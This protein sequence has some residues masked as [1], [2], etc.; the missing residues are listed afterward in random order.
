MRPKGKIVH[1]PDRADVSLCSRSI[2]FWWA[3]CYNQNMIRPSDLKLAKQIAPRV[4]ALANE[5]IKEVN[6][7]QMR[8]LGACMHAMEQAFG[9]DK[10][11]SLAV[12]RYHPFGLPGEANALLVGDEI[13]WPD[14]T[15]G[16][17]DKP[18]FEKGAQDMSR[19]SISEVCWMS[20]FAAPSVFALS[21]KLH[22]FIQQWLIDKQ[23]GLAPSISR[24][25]R[26]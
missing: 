26:I 8:A 18:G 25:H 24:S 2:W 19:A 3:L 21:D 14:G 20:G 13:F 15:T 4:V 16:W 1:H 12:G 10:R 9:N 5:H 11:L 7:S 6:G 17:P 22:A 23:V